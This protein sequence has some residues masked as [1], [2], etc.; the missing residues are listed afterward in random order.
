MKRDKL[1]FTWFR[2]Y[3]TGIWHAVGLGLLIGCF[4]YEP[5]RHRLFDRAFG[6]LIGSSVFLGIGFV[7]NLPDLVLGLL[8]DIRRFRAAATPHPFDENSSPTP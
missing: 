7:S 3:W 4:V 1:P 6:D 5:L 8:K 2:G